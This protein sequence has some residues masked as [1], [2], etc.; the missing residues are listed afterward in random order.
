MIA[1]AMLT[2]CTQNQRAK[3]WGG[4][5]TI[6]LPKHTKLVTATWKNNNLWYST[7][8]MRAGEFAEATSF[9]EDSSWGAI[10]GT[11]IF[12]ESN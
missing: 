6:N 4:T 11:V 8:P 9:Q 5:A 7:R 10:Q 3:S 12:N 2:S 1:I